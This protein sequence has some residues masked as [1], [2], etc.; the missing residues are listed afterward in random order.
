V[1]E[2]KMPDCSC[3]WF[4]SLLELSLQDAKKSAEIAKIDINFK[5]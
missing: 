5:R 2:D 4:L 3:D 1:D